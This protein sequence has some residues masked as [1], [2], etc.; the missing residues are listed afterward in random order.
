MQSSENI[1]QIAA[2][3]A[4][5]QGNCKMVGKSAHNK[6]DNYRY[7]DLEDYL[8][9][10][11]PEL[12]KEGLAVITSMATL[13]RLDNRKTKSG[14]EDNVVQAELDITIVHKSGQ[15]IRARMYGEGQDRADKSIYKATT[16]ARKYAIASLFNLATSDDPERD[17]SVGIGRTTSAVSNTASVNS[18]TTAKPVNP[19]AVTNAPLHNPSAVA[20]TA[21]SVAKASDS[22]PA[23]APVKTAETTAA[24]AIESAAVAA[25]KKVAVAKKPVEKAPEKP[26]E[27]VA[28]KEV[29]K[30]A[31]GGTLVG[32]SGDPDEIPGGEDMGQKCTANCAE[33][34]SLRKEFQRMK[35]TSR[36]HCL[37]VVNWALNR[38][39]SDKISVV[40]DMTRADAKSVRD[41]IVASG[42]TTVRAFLEKAGLLET[43]AV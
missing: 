26:A 10:I 31:D 35:I 29:V 7:A 41:K 17:E 24:A 32:H 4:N 2:A 28:A 34:E 11:K 36:Q 39:D 20:S 22:R 23:N 40:T 38:S 19:S 6:F 8:A 12:Y 5:V 42:E 1:D 37:A 27:K 13:N 9:V 18:V 16:G 15:W 21:A 43:A 25:D 3:L 30:T 33:M 14:S